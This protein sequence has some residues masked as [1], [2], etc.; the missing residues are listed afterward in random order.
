MKDN[1]S[2][3]IWESFVSNQSRDKIG[4]NEYSR[5]IKFPNGYEA[6][7]ISKKG[8]SYGGDTGLFE[9]AVFD[10]EGNYINIENGEP[11]GAMGDGVRG[12]LDFEEVAQILKRIRTFRNKHRVI[13]VESEVRPREVHKLPLH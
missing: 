13:D 4:N 12:H 10:E 11:E 9:I 2:K 7:V 8:R 5:N 6:S 1:D 3:L